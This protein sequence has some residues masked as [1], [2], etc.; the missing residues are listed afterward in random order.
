GL[1]FTRFPA[2][3]DPAPDPA[4]DGS[5][6][7]A[8]VRL[9]AVGRAVEKKGFDHLLE[10]LAAL[11]PGLHWRLVHIGGGPLSAALRTR[12]RALGL[13][14]RVAWRGPQPQQAV[15]AACRDA[16]LFVLPCRIAADG[17]RDGLPNV[18]MEAQSQRLAVLSTRVSGVPEL[19]EDG[20][21]GMLVPPGD[22]AALS[23]A[24]AALIADPA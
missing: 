6:A 21:T 10:A 4:R 18:L 24:L 13:A 2:P 14:D 12:A 1:D 11:P 20:V 8:P 5:D 23:A 17:D 22:P 3:P 16:D 15:L 7:A 19:I 9:L